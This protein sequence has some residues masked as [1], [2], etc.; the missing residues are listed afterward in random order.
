MDSNDTNSEII[1]IMNLLRSKDIDAIDI[2][3]FIENN[4]VVVRNC[5]RVSEFAT[6]LFN[7]GY[8]ITITNKDILKDQEDDSIKHS[9]DTYFLIDLNT[10]SK[11]NKDTNEYSFLEA[12]TDAFSADKSFGCQKYFKLIRNTNRSI[13]E[14]SEER[15]RL[16]Y[17]VDFQKRNTYGEKINKLRLDSEVLF[18]HYKD[19]NLVGR[20]FGELLEVPELSDELDKERDE[21]IENIGGRQLDLLFHNTKLDMTPS[22]IELAHELENKLTLE[23]VNKEDKLEFKRVIQEPKK[24]DEFS[25]YEITLEDLLDSGEEVHGVFVPGDKRNNKE[26]KYIQDDIDDENEL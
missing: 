26:N 25:D 16:I 21:Y 17:T 14:V 9:K 23:P 11:C 5:P 6:S 1:N 4:I 18:D 13:S 7:R 20:V 2:D 12:A 24:I 22:L 15:T 3:E 10:K 8:Q 19:L